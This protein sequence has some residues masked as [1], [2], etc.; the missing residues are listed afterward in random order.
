MQQRHDLGIRLDS[1]LSRECRDVHKPRCDRDTRGKVKPAPAMR[2][3][4]GHVGPRDGI[5]DMSKRTST[6]RNKRPRWFGTALGPGIVDWSGSRIGAALEPC[7]LSS[8]NLLFPSV[9]TGERKFAAPSSGRI[10]RSRSTSPRVCNWMP[11]A[12]V[13]QHETIVAPRSM[14]VLRTSNE[15]EPRQRCSRSICSLALQR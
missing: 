10:G 9:R 12:M 5:C 3:S 7:H 13:Q 1:A 11:I 6:T 14:R 2:Q 15:R 8:E 4:P